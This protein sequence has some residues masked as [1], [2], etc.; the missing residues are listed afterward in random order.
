[1]YKYSTKLPAR[2]DVV[3]DYDRVIKQRGKIVSGIFDKVP[4]LNGE[5]IKDSWIEFSRSDH[6]W[7][8]VQQLQDCW[9]ESENAYVINYVEQ[10]EA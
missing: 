5:T 2:G 8:T 6:E 9:V 1:M 4:S 7:Y 3:I 10:S